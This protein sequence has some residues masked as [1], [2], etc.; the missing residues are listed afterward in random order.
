MENTLNRMN[1]LLS[2]NEHIW[3]CYLPLFFSCDKYYEYDLSNN[4]NSSCS[5]TRF[6]KRETLI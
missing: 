1:L 3:Y 4:Q 5:R 2:I 6:G